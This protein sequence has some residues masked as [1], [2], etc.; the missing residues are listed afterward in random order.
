MPFGY[1]NAYR[2]SQ[3]ATHSTATALSSNLPLYKDFTTMLASLLRRT[4]GTGSEVNAE[5]DCR[6]DRGL[7][8]LY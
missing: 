7:T 8:A 4:K 3:E 1:S 5:E 2:P 6:G